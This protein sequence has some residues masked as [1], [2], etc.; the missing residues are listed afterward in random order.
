MAQNDRIQLGQGLPLSCTN[1]V[2]GAGNTKP[3]KDT[4]VLALKMIS[5]G[6]HS[7]NNG[8]GGVQLHGPGKPR[9]QGTSPKG[10]NLE[11]RSGLMSGK[12]TASQ[13]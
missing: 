5:E 3:K 13:I 8:K 10:S 9:A 4:V 7:D 11:E 12:G 6:V 1:S 2:Q